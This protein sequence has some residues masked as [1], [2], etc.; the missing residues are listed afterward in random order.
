MQRSF[1]LGVA[2]GSGSGKTTFVAKLREAWRNEVSILQADSYYH[3]ASHLPFDERAR[4]N[5]DCM[6]AIDVDLLV[7]HLKTLRAGHAIETPIYDFATHTRLAASNTIEPARWVVLEGIMVLATE[8]IRSELDLGVFVDAAEDIRYQ[9]RLSR[10]LE[11]R[12]RSAESVHRQWLD[13]VKPFHDRLIEPSKQ[14]ADIVIRGD[15]LKPV[16]A[17]LGQLR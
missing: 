12:G 2:G 13:S 16:F 7:E 14:A 6:E 4:L 3:D 17:L 15:N 8:Q 9:R 1:L 5:F 11:T 10:D